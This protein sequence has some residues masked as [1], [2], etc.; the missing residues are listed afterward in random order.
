MRGNTMSYKILDLE[1]VFVGN[2][3]FLSWC[4]GKQ[5]KHLNSSAPSPSKSIADWSPLM[6]CLLKSASQHLLSLGLVV[7]LTPLF[8]THTGGA[9]IF[10]IVCLFFTYF[11]LRSFIDFSHVFYLFSPWPRPAATRPEILKKTFVFSRFSTENVDFAWRF[12]RLF[13]GR[14]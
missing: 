12:F 3:I 11:C 1:N 14:L 9:P 13:W 6:C 4:C 8:L 10:L 2:L 7:A 5:F